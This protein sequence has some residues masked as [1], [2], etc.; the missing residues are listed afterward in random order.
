MAIGGGDYPPRFERLAA[1]AAAMT[2]PAGGRFKRTLAGC[3]VERREGG[4]VFYREFGRD[5]AG[6]GRGEARG[7]GRLGPPLPRHAPGE[8]VPA[9]ARPWRRSAR[10][11]AAQSAPAAAWRR[12]ARLPRSPPSAAA[13]A[14][15]RSRRSDYFANSAKGLDVTIGPILGQRLAEPPLFPDF[16]AGL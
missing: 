4:F 15:S 3:V 6:G 16:S 8:T 5:G 12:P 1:L 10:R 14:S 2:A 11:A 7:D 9:G 13:G